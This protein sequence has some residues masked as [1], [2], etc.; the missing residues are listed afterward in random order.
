MP[1]SKPILEINTEHPIVKKLDQEKADDRFKDLSEFL[2]DQAILAEGG[3]LDDPASF[4]HKLNEM[5]AGVAE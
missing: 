1:G 2:F 4:V 3:Q 5:L